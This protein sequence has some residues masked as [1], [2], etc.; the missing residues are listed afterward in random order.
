[1]G[2]SQKSDKGAATRAADRI[3]AVGPRAVNMLDEMVTTTFDVIG[4]VTVSGG[5]TFDRDK[6][7]GAIDYY[8]AEVGKISLFDILGAPGWILRPGRMMSGEALKKD[9]GD[10]R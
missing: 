2:H 6:V 8:I 5:D 4:D 10:D 7:H 3:T 1:M 9:Q